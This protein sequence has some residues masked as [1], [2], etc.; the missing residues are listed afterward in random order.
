MMP[1]PGENREF[2]FFKIM[3]KRT[4][5]QENDHDFLDHHKIQLLE[6]LINPCEEFVKFCCT[7]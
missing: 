4:M 6:M 3:S 7:A 5:S 1:S 2:Q